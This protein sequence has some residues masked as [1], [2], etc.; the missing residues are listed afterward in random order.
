MKPYITLTLLLLN[1][2][3]FAQPKGD[4]EYRDMVYDDHIK[5]V[6]L[7][8]F[9]EP[10]AA[11]TA[12]PIISLR[13][14]RHLI[15]EF[16]EL[17]N[18][19]YDYRAK[20]I[21]CNA[22]WQPSDLSPLQYLKEYNEYNITDAEYSFG[23]LTEYVH[24]KFIV[25]KPII[26][27]NYL[28]VVYAGGDEEDVIITRRFMVFEQWVSFTDKL[29]IMRN[30]P[31]SLTRQQLQFSIDYRNVDL[32]NPMEYVSVNILQNQ[33]WDNAKMDLKPSF[34]RESQ[35]ILEYNQYG[36]ENSFL[37]GNEFR[38]F[39][40]RSLKYFGFHVGNVSFKKDKIFAWVETDKPRAGLAYSIE[41][42][43]KGQYFIENLE[44][45]IPDIENDYALV[46]FTLASEKLN[47][48]VYLSGKFT[49][50]RH[51]TNT[52]MQY[53]EHTAQY[54]GTYVLKQGQ[55]DYQYFVGTA[56]K[57][58]EIEGNKRETKNRYDILVYYRS[59][60]LQADLLV[61]YYTFVYDL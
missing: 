52:R 11:Q 20:I 26:S 59:Q 31:Y 48:P 50:W 36:E 15:L 49:D 3:S 43:I 45:K 12:G 32:V 13:G 41:N 25:P 46:T 44:R 14:N 18:D 19:I 27:G 28:L 33:R 47:E 39:D 21:H 22:N 40:I 42:N 51:D 7:Y 58:N 55:Y 17:F 5:T 54:E 38:Y 4:I 30:A 24:Y 23:T 2:I 10:V 35:R 16:D 29:Q 34:A 57:E 60:K 61:G 56:K 53:N 6:Q 8:P 37:A 9:A 1:T